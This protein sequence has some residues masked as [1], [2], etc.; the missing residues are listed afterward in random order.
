M[1]NLFLYTLVLMLISNS[2][3]AQI[4]YQDRKSKRDEKNKRINAIIKQEE[5]GVIH[6]KTHFAGGFKLVNDGY[7]GF[8]EYGKAQSVNKALLFQFEI[9]E[10]KHSKEEKSTNPYINSAPF[11]YGKMN[12][13]Y[14]LKLGVQQQILLGNK[15]NRNGVSVSCNFGGGI[16]LGFL[17]PYLVEVANAENLSSFVDYETLYNQDYNIKD[18]FAVIGG[19]SFGQ[20]WSKLKMIPGVYVKSALRF[21]YGKYNEVI[22]GLEIGASLEYYSKKIPQMIAIKQNQLFLGVYL[23]LIFGK[24]K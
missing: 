19:P 6:Y 18:S 8:L 15:G 23:S 4:K 2:L 7:G 11:I 1:K 5:E 17:R 22:S 24:R 21:D 13:F 12:F 20:G 9:D 16:S 10:R 3:S 14:P